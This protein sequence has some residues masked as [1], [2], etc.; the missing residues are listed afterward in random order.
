MSGNQQQVIESDVIGNSFEC[1][2]IIDAYNNMLNYKIEV[3]EKA[4]GN[5]CV[6]YFS[7][8]GLWTTN[9]VAE[10]KRDYVDGNKFEWERTRIKGAKKSIF[11]R[12]VFK[13]SYVI[14]VN[15]DMNNLHKMIQFL[16]EET[17]DYS[18]ITVGSSSGG[19]AAFVTG[20]ILDA[21]GIFSFTG[22][23][24]IYHN[25]IKHP[26]DYG[27]TSKFREFMDNPEWNQYFNILNTHMVDTC[28]IPIYY[29]SSNEKLDVLQKNLILAHDNVILFDMD[30]NDH[31]RPVY[32]FNFRD[33]LNM[34]GYDLIQ[35]HYKYYGKKI[36]RFR[37]SCEVSGFK[38]TVKRL[39]KDKFKKTKK[40][41]D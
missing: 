30:S 19:Y 8:N 18:V 34:P 35:L 31:R 14:G 26:L 17:K 27:R 21:V 38:K 16:K 33:I 25:A 15:K 36:S 23:F 41:F 9:S 22:Q 37:F 28:N 10:F 1:P 3:D 5:L 32:G 2:A 39:L 29:F 11:M 7:S 24:S 6:V 20:V 12:D 4:E 13:N 40:L